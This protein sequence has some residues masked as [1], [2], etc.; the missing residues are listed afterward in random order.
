MKLDPAAG[1]E[2][3]MRT[4]DWGA[5]LNGQHSSAALSQMSLLMAEG[6]ASSLCEAQLADGGAS[7]AGASGTV[8]TGP[9]SDRRCC[10]HCSCGGSPRRE[11]NTFPNGEWPVAAPRVAPSAFCDSKGVWKF[12]VLFEVTFELK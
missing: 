2:S 10:C 11:G 12:Q 1:G 9:E 5:L 3:P 6:V 8:Y 4:G 7:P